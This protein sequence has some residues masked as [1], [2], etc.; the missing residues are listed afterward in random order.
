MRARIPSFLRHAQAD[1]LAYACHKSAFSFSR[2]R[3]LFLS[4][5]SPSVTQNPRSPCPF[6][7]FGYPQPVLLHRRSTPRPPSACALHSSSG[8]GNCRTAVRSESL[9]RTECHARLQGRGDCSDV[10]LSRRDPVRDTERI[11][12]PRM[13]GLPRYELNS[14]ERGHDTSPRLVS[15]RLAPSAEETLSTRPTSEGRARTHN[16]GTRVSR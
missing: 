4:R 10:L 2:S 1:T 9:T 5:I 7:L 13:P 8:S 16:H 3:L 11:G 14:P 12:I 6:F 15:S